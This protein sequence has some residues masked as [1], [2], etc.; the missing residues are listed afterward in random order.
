MSTGYL[1][2]IRAGDDVYGSDGEKVG[3]I[4]AVYPGYIVVEKGFFFPTDYYIPRSAVNTAEAGRVYLTVTKEAALHSGWDVVPGNLETATIT[5]GVIADPDP[6]AAARIDAA[7]EEIRVPVIEE[8][9][10]ATGR[11]AAA[12]AVRV[13]KRVVAEEQTLEVPVTEERL[14]IERRVVDRPASGVDAEILEDT[15]IEVPLRSET[16]EVQKEARV[17]EEVVISKEAVQRTERVTDTVRREEVFI[18]EE[19]VVDTDLV[20]GSDR[21][22]QPPS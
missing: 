3:T 11:P 14:R 12:G 4:A 1:A 2:E 8:E 5:T 15:V 6:L 17:A 20:E 10:T 13:E 22:S 16:V 9:L 18:D 21:G 7:A 19:G